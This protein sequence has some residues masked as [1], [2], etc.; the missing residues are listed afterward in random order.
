MR[1]QVR[2]VAVLALCVLWVGGC[3]V[4]MDDVGPVGPPGPQGETGQQGLT[5]PQGATGPQG[6]EGPPG[7]PGPAEAAAPV[8]WDIALFTMTQ[9]SEPRVLASG[10][11][12][13][14][15]LQVFGTVRVTLFDG[16]QPITL[17]TVGFPGVFDANFEAG[18]TI[19]VTGFDP[20]KPDDTSDIIVLFRLD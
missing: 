2:P 3:P 16:G 1:N 20:A 5:G 11:G 15:E 12:I 8:G 6:P 7:P 9:F 4:A 13:L 18:L 17:D 19:E 10:P 14:H